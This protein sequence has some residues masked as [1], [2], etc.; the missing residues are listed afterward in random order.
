LAAMT[1]NQFFE[2]YPSDRRA[3]VPLGLRVNDLVL[4]TGLTGGREI[5][6]AAVG[7]VEE[8][9]AVALRRLHQAL[10]GAGL[11]FEDVRRVTAWLAPDEDRDDLSIPWSAAFSQHLRGPALEVRRIP[12]PAGRLVQLDAFARSDSGKR[13]DW[14]QDEVEW[15]REFSG[16]A[17]EP[18]GFRLGPILFSPSLGPGTAA[19]SDTLYQLR[20]ALAAMDAFLEEAGSSRT[21]VGRVTFFLR[22]VLER[23]IL[24]QVWAEWFPDPAELPPHKYV[25]A[26][27]PEGQNVR[28]Q[29][30]ALPGAART[31]LEIPS[32]RH[33][34][35]MSMGAR[36]DNLVFSSR[37]IAGAAA[38]SE[39]PFSVE[40]HVLVLWRHA[41][42][43]L[44]QAGGEIA[45]LAQATFFIG[46]A[47]FQ[48][49][50]ESTFGHL[51]AGLRS[52]LRLNVIH[53]DLGTGPVPR[54]EIVGVL[55]SSVPA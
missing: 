15:F 16:S 19:G 32:V 3:T 51:S 43:L 50:V 20:A 18:A 45:D 7:D 25:P 33:G 17:I 6:G 28:V 34:D 5:G 41:T 11:A 55:G 1:V 9:M 22:D 39:A 26:S 53:A 14:P 13:R 24:N 49:P 4:L 27:L 21:E 37:I 54:L 2:I 42:T 30:L 31:V 35:P 8:Q 12:L 47:A 44:E 48:G 52:R 40:D 23:P 46:D 29:V 38:R 36:I 10:T